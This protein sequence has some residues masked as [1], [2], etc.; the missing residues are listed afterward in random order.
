MVMIEVVVNDRLGRKIRV[1][2]DNEETI[3]E[4]KKV[5]AA[6]CGTRPEKLKIQKWNMV[7]KDHITLADYEVNDGMGLELF[8]N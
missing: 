4:L 3:G 7:F 6:K 5:V 2:I 1:K 8:Y